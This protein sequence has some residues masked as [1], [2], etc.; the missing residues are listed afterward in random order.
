MPLIDRESALAGI[1]ARDAWTRAAASDIATT[2]R[3]LIAWPD[4]PEEHRRSGTSFG[5]EIGNALRPEDVFRRAHRADLIAIAF[6]AFSDGRG[7]S[8]GRSLR[9]LGYTG[10]LRAVGPLIPDQFA[11]AL[12]CGFNEIE[13]PE[14]SAARQ[15]PQHWQRA[16]RQFTGT[17]QRGFEAGGVSILDARR[18]ARDAAG[19]SA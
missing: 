5:V 12:A 16:L 10:R 8:L 15:A 11:Y 9:N 2:V 17:Y 14:A 6:P 18:A 19:G 13:L 4:L 1:W 3:P 7:F